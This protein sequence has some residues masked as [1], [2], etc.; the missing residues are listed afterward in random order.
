MQ[1]GLNSFQLKIIAVI[2]MT[3]DHIQYF[4]FGTLAVPPILGMIGR[5]AAPIFLFL[6]ASSMA[7]TSSQSKY[8]IRLYVASVLMACLNFF[9][10]M[11]YVSVGGVYMIGNIFQTM[12]LACLLIYAYEMIKVG[13]LEKDS[14]SYVRGLMI[15]FMMILS[16]VAFLFNLNLLYTTQSQWSM[17]ANQLMMI[18]VPNVLTC[19]GSIVIVLMAFGFYFCLKN[20]KNLI[21]YYTA[22]SGVFLFSA[23]ASEFSLQNIFLI[24]YQWLQ[25]LALPFL[26]AYNNEKGRGMKYFFYVYYPL[27]MVILFCLQLFL[28]N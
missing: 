25:I 18:L 9:I 20:Q 11:N 21:F 8:I 10:N 7:H 5:I 26:L 16:T 28:I 6:M 17:I 22:V 13:I 24:N 2:F 3:L 12:T 27:H 19:E 14:R 1:K 23:L 15:L 4:L